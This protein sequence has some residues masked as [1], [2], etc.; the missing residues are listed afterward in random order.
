MADHRLAIKPSR[1]GRLY[2][3]HCRRGGSDRYRRWRSVF[4]GTDLRQ[5]RRCRSC[6]TTKA[7]ALSW[8]AIRS[9]RRFTPWCMPSTI[10]WAL[11]AQR[12]LTSMASNHSPPNPMI[13]WPNWLRTWIQRC[14][15]DA[16]LSSNV[17]PATASRRTSISPSRCRLFPLRKTSMAARDSSASVTACMEDETSKFCQWHLLRPLTPWNVGA[18]CVP[19]RAPLRWPSR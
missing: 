4:H 5:I 10:N 13:R 17:I 2:I 11:P 3:R 9:R 8:L 18:I 15:G 19:S 16:A 14:R 12:L 7:R 6:P 1:I